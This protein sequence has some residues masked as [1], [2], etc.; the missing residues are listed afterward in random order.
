MLCD[1]RKI[2]LIDVKTFERIASFNLKNV[3]TCF[4]SEYHIAAVTTNGLYIL[5]LTGEQL[6]FIKEL[7][8]LSTL[9]FHPTHNIIAAATEDGSIHIWDFKK[10]CSVLSIRFPPDVVEVLHFTSDGQL[11]VR[12]DLN[13]FEINLDKSMQFL[14]ASKRG[15][16]IEFDKE[17][18]YMPDRTE[19][20]TLR[21]GEL[22]VRDRQIGVTLRQMKRTFI[23]Y[24]IH[25]KRHLIAGD[26]GRGKILVW[27][28]KTL[29]LQ[30][31]L[32]FRSFLWFFFGSDDV[33]HVMT[34]V[35]AQ[36]VSCDVRP[37]A[38]TP[39]RVYPLD[40]FD[41][42]EIGMLLLCLV[43]FSFLLTACFQSLP[44][45]RGHRRLRSYGYLK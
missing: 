13:T 42:F 29:T 12:T 22:Q 25:S 35:P 7:A 31:V 40:K 38:I 15:D 36:I 32:E 24:Q 28:T 26:V 11:F 2:D 3:L 34:N 33:L 44:A 16:V 39:D 43:F 23:N 9:E 19:F 21:G 17:V 37:G 4:T 45:S 18:N 8:G 14:S 6:D 41:V 27:S 20:F 1:S 30:R 5:S 10:R